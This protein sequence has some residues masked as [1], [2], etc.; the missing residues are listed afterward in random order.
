MLAVE[1]N[2]STS[3]GRTKTDGWIASLPGCLVIINQDQSHKLNESN[4]ESR[5]VGIHG[6]SGGKKVIGG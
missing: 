2:E 3:F 1:M 5:L 6:A 4:Y